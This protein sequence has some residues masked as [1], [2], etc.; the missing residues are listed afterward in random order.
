MTGMENVG[1][2]PRMDLM[3][4]YYGYGYTAYE[5]TTDDGY[6]LTAFRITGRIGSD[7]QPTKPPVVFL[8]NRSGDGAGLMEWAFSGGFDR[9]FMLRLADDGYDVY[10]G[11]NRGTEYSRKHVSLD[12]V[13]DAEEYWDFSWA[14]FG[15]Y[16]DKAFI[17]LAVN[18]SSYDKAFYLG[19]S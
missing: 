5:V 2:Y 9:P 11:N 16:D 13:T 1:Q 12:S 7:Y 6:I 3:M 17:D 18:Q 4:N 10:L 8:H 15:L 19:L 14:E